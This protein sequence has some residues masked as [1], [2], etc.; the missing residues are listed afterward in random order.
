MRTS[1]VADRAGVNTQTLRYYER[2]GL[3]TEPP[4]SPCGYRQYPASAVSVLRFV[5]R[6]QELGFTLAEV[7]DLLAPAD[8][9]PRSC[10]RARA[11]AEAHLD[12][13]DRKIADLHRMR[14]SLA[15]LVATSERPRRDRSCP[16]LDAIDDPTTATGGAR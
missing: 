7:A 2:R 12:E 3:L 9:G 14:A 13:L 8:G 16:L 5:K 6:A 15:R 10:E 4:R 11:L 1:E